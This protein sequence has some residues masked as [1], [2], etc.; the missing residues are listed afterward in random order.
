MILHDEV[1]EYYLRTVGC[2]EQDIDYF[3]EFL[4]QYGELDLSG[5]SRFHPQI[6]QQANKVLGEY[7]TFTKLVKMDEEGEGYYWEVELHKYAVDLPCKV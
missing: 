1:I 4:S 2:D 7:L 5:Y 6:L 3:G